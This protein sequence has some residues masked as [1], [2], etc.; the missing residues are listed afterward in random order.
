MW[1]PGLSAAIRRAHGES[2]W[3]TAWDDGVVITNV[4]SSRSSLRTSWRKSDG[5]STCSR[6]SLEWITSNFR[7]CSCSGSVSSSRYSGKPSALAPASPYCDGSTPKT[8]QPYSLAD[9]IDR[10]AVTASDVEKRAPA[11][12]L[13]G[14]RDVR[15]EDDDAGAAL[16]V[17]L[18]AISVVGVPVIIRLR[19]GIV[20][21]AV[22]SLAMK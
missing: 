14:R 5:F 4:P 8:S 3:F 2:S 19:H 9:K 13:D 6:T 21:V 1:N 20:E 18:D 10:K 15:G 12:H 16:H 17:S 7:P 11:F 22:A